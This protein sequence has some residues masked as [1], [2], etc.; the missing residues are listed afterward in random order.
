[1]LLAFIPCFCGILWEVHKISI[2][3]KKIAEQNERKLDLLEKLLE[4]IE[5]R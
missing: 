4:K 3:H 5:H 1:M 2:I